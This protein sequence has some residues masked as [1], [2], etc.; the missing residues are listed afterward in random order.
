MTTLDMTLD[1]SPYLYVY[2]AENEKV[3]SNSR[4]GYF[5][6]RKML[7]MHAVIKGDLM[8]SKESLF[9]LGHQLSK[10]PPPGHQ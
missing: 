1:L 5:M 7:L 9:S 4:V 3:N 8:V 2:L 6:S 10:P